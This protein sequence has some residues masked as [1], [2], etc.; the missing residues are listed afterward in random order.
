MEWLVLIVLGMTCAALYARADSLELRTEALGEQLSHLRVRIAALEPTPASAAPRRRSAAAGPGRP[1]VAVAPTPAAPAERPPGSIPPAAPDIPSVAA[2]APVGLVPEAAS[3]AA[4]AAVPAMPPSAAAPGAPAADKARVAVPDPSAAVTPGRAR[5]ARAE[6]AR[7]VAPDRPPAATPEL[8][9]AP[10]S[11]PAPAPDQ[12]SDADEKASQAELVFAGHY[13][14]LAGVAVL[15]LG[16]VSLLRLAWSGGIL[17]CLAGLGLGLALLWGGDRAWREGRRG[18]SDPM[19]AG[20]FGLLLLTLGAAHFYF[21]LIPRAGL[22]VGLAG[23]VAWSGHAALRYDSRLVGTVILGGLFLSPS[24]MTFRLES[25]GLLATYLLAIGVGSAWVAFH[26]R[27]DLQLIA[28]FLGSYALFLHQFGLQHPAETMGF[29]TAL[30][31]LYLAASQALLLNREES[32]GYDVV[33]SFVNPLAFALVGYLLL[34]KLPSAL[35]VLAYAGIGVVHLALSARARNRDLANGHLTMGLLF[36]TAAVSF[37]TYLSTTTSWFS[38][39]T[40]LW[41]AEAFATRAAARR[42]PDGALILRR[43]AYLSLL[44]AS[45]QLAVVI[46]T[47]EDTSEH[48]FSERLLLNLASAGLYLGW[49]LAVRAA[50][51]ADREEDVAMRLS[52][53]AGAAVLGW[54]SLEGLSLALGTTVA[55][56]LALVTLAVALGLP[57]ELRFLRY[58]A[59]ALA[60]GSTA[61]ALVLGPEMPMACALQIALLLAGSALLRTRGEEHRLPLALAGLLALRLALL[62]GPTALGA[63]AVALAW[64]ARRLPVE[65]EVLR[66]LAVLGGLVALAL[67]VSGSAPGVAL[68]LVALAL[69]EPEADSRPLW[70]LAAAL[71]AARAA[72]ELPPEAALAAGAL[73]ALALAWVRLPLVREVAVGLAAVLALVGLATPGAAGAVFSALALAGVTFA[74][75]AEDRLAWVSG[76][77]ALVAGFHAVLEGVSGPAATLVWALAGLALLGPRPLLARVALFA[78][79]MKAILLDGTFQVGGKGVEVV[80]TGTLTPGEGLAMAGLLACLALAAR[81]SRPHSE[82]RNAYA[83]MAM[84]CF[85]FQSARVMYDGFGV[86]DEFQVLLSAFWCAS[87]FAMVAWGIF[88]ELRVCRLFGLTILVAAAAKILLVDLWV[89]NAYSKTTTLLILGALLMAVSFLYQGNQVRL[90]RDPEPVPA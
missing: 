55:A 49:F 41:F 22:F 24:L 1:R 28:A 19:L 33:L 51:P 48:L 31:L 12:P 53:V 20:G 81:L 38:A 39:V 32:S 73:L 35:A 78:S 30:Y 21:D 2:L 83:L 15:C 42:W 90:A 56:A 74:L 7:L 58:A 5:V 69:L 47:M 18:Y 80:L 10:A 25:L 84:A 70:V 50:R 43:Y 89:L 9:P 14:N 63:A 64:A 87:A 44:L 71:A 11:R 45:A 67:A 52:A 76:L 3:A 23:L 37:V 8:P 13:L 59:L 86:L 82:P 16:G 65:A 79:F 68:A 85:L 46:P 54:I 61:V 4:R 72:W 62:A 77:A 75:R 29:L 40:L 17:Q 34:L 60:L 26:R 6:K 88:G 66:G 27:W 57:L 36:L